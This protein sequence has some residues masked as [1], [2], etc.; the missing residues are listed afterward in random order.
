MYTS[1]EEQ[2]YASFNAAKATIL[3]LLSSSPELQTPKA[4]IICGSGL[5]G[6]AGILKGNTVKIPYTSI[7]GFKTSTVPGHEGCLLFGLIGSNKVPVMCMVGRLHFYEG[8][9]F[10]S[11]TFPIRVAKLLGAQYLIVTNAAGG[12]NPTYKPGD[13]MI[14]NDH[15]NLPGVAGYHPL[16]GGNLSMFGPRFL[17]LSDAYDFK[18]RL[19]LV[20]I[21]KETLKLTRNIHEGVYCFAA[22]PTF[23]T[24]A[25]IRFIKGIGGDSVGMSTV[26]EVIVARHCDMKVLGLSLITNAGLSEPPVNASEFFAKGNKLDEAKDQTDGMASHDEVLESANEAAEDVKKL[27]ECFINELE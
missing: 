25:E 7:P 22:G 2:T 4:L 18:L 13:L 12:M 8:Y 19:S 3:E 21:A 17:P 20:K 27:I 14:I 26:P 9:S 15:L 1:E 23:E 11:T 24:R 6:I 16:R 10:E 5:G